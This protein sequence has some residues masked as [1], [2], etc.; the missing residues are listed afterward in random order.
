M[1]NDRQPKKLRLLNELLLLVLNETYIEVLENM[2]TDA[3]V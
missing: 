3:G 1:V 2:N